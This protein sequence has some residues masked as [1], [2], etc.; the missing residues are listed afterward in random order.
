M[1]VLIL[2]SHQSAEILAKDFEALRLRSSVS[3]ESEAEPRSVPLPKIEYQGKHYLTAQLRYTKFVKRVTLQRAL[4]SKLV[5]FPESVTRTD[6]LL[7][8]DN[9]LYVQDIARTNENFRIKFGKSLEV[10]TKIL[11]GFR[12]SSK[13]TTANVVQLS[14]V[15]RDNLQGFYFPERNTNT[16]I[17]KAEKMYRITP[18][19]SLGRDKSRVPPKAYI[20]KGYTDHGTAKDPAIDGSPSWQEVASKD[21][22]GEFRENDKDTHLGKDTVTE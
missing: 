4:V 2:G 16:E 19:I 21:I 3:L 13:T 15:M 7:A 10:L 6:I 22:D 8:Y 11:R 9:L 1:E 14:K 18:F 5:H 17:K 20:G 12:L